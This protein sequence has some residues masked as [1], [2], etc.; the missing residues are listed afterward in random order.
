MFVPPLPPL[1]FAPHTTGSCPPWDA[2]KSQKKHSAVTPGSIGGGI[3][4]QLAHAV[5]V[6]RDSLQPWGVYPEYL[7]GGVAIVVQVGLVC[8]PP[9]D[10]VHHLRRTLLAA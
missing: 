4:Q 9:Q 3:R 1:P 6:L 10:E 7:G 5:G 2:S 8:A